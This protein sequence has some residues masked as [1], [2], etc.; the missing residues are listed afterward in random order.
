MENASQ[1]DQR[2]SHYLTQQLIEN[3]LLKKENE[4]YI[5][6][7]QKDP[8]QSM[9][10]LDTADIVQDLIHIMKGHIKDYKTGD[11]IERKGYE[12]IN[13]NGIQD[14][15]VISFQ[16]LA[17]KNIYLSNFDEERC[18]Y[19]VRERR[20]KIVKLIGFHNKEYGISKTHRDFIVD[21]VTSFIASAVFRSKDGLERRGRFSTEIRKYV[22]GNSRE[23]E[24][25][26][27]EKK[28]LLGIGAFGL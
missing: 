26:V 17:N 23:G 5:N 19:L 18:Y 8:A 1:P 12:L 22:Y 14:I 21:I 7:P 28:G 20:I 3:E 25:S 24:G 27:K 13:D 4:P 10:E 6:M 2:N 15:V 9:W 16:T 11:W